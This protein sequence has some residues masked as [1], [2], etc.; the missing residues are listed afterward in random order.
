[1]AL[2]LAPS[3]LKKWFASV[4]NCFGETAA[5]GSKDD[6]SPVRLQKRHFFVI[7]DLEIFCL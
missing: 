4:Y 6:G 2:L 5:T 7:L 3:A 1:M